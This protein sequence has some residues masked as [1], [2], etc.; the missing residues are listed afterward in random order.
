MKTKFVT[1]TICLPLKYYPIESK[2]YK[3]KLQDKKQKYKTYNGHEYKFDGLYEK[4]SKCTAGLVIKNL[5]KT[6]FTGGI[7]LFSSDLRDDWQAAFR[8]KRKI[9]VYKQGVC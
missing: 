8:G 7:L 3:A 1:N 4:D 5:A 9:A 2:K 6:I